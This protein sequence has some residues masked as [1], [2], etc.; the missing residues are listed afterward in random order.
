L[1]G[2]AVHPE[3]MGHCCDCSEQVLEH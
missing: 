2:E 1:L 3:P